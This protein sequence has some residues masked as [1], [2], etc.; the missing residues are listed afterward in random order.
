[1]RTESPTISVKEAR[2]ILGKQYLAFSDEQ[3]VDIITL[4]NAIAKDF[5]RVTVPN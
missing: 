4:L 5:V 2:K 3:I 1:M